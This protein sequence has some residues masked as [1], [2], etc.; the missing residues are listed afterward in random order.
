MKKQANWQCKVV[1][2]AMLAVA[3]VIGGNLN[4]V[5]QDKFK[6]GD[7]VE[8]EVTGNPQGKWWSKGTIMP[9]KPGDFGSGMEPD[10]SWYRVKVDSNKVEYPCKPDVLRRIGG[11]AVTTKPG[12]VKTPVN[13]PLENTE[14]EGQGNFL[15]CPVAQKKVARGGAPNVEL[16]KK[17]IR[18]HKGEKDVDEGDEG[19]VGVE[20]ASVQIGAAR[21]W[22]YSQDNGN[23]K[24]GTL[25]YPVKA[26][27]TVRTFY[28]NATEV[29]E[30]WI[31]ILNFYVNAFGEWQI[32]SEEPVKAP[33]TRR[34]PK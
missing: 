34:I 31:R 33:K 20:I 27:Y 13:E 2:T 16:F 18:C 25:V 9:F 3:F 8:C 11:E 12:R 10:G 19:A 24:P 1:V 17:I 22:S 21:P 30:G 32:G 26:T 15:D 6:V 14:T 28:R 7:R 23:S 29:E 4:A 5:A